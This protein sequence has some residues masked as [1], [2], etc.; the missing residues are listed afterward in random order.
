MADNNEEYEF[1]Y[2]EDEA[3][4]I[5]YDWEKA[6]LNSIPASIVFDLA[7]K[8]VQASS[9]HGS[10]EYI[11]VDTFS[12]SKDISQ[13]VRVSILKQYILE[14]RKDE[15]TQKGPRKE[16][17]ETLLQEIEKIIALKREEKAAKREEAVAK[18]KIY[19]DETL[20]IENEINNYYKMLEKEKIKFKT[21]PDGIKIYAE[22]DGNQHGFIRLVAPI[23]FARHRG[24]VT[25]D[26]I[27][28]LKEGK[29][30]IGEIMIEWIVIQAYN[31]GIDLEFMAAPKTDSNVK[32]SED[33]TRLYKYYENIGFNRKSHNA[34]T[35]N[36]EG[37]PRKI[38]LN[39]AK[40][41][42]ANE[43]HGGAGAHGGRRRINTYKKRY[44]IHK[45]HTRRTKSRRYRI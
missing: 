34:N 35:T 14:L 24:V 9:G 26:L 11:A 28:R 12:D 22:K 29:K 27:K 8:R 41:H 25:I 7:L 2:S 23:D 15:Q 16:T 10:P 39:F 37:K 30:G 6:N 42:N 13:S 44:A 17:L 4:S 3:E 40:K 21:E 33:P 38:L 1:S 18:R 31:N 20:L 5:N 43:P 19:D 32:V 45:R 36:Y